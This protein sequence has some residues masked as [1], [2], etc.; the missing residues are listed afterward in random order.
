MHFRSDDGA[1]SRSFSTGTMKGTLKKFAS[2]GSMKTTKLPEHMLQA[3][4]KDPGAIEA[5]M[6]DK[7][8]FT[9][10]SFLS[11]FFVV[12]LF[13]FY[14]FNFLADLFFGCF[15]SDPPHTNLCWLS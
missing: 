9:T 12:L 10:A 11:L 4:D 3:K 14:F 6:G 1:D 15:S 5:E 13:L 7:I 2:T 8:L